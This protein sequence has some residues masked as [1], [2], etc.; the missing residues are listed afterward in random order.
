MTRVVNEGNIDKWLKEF[1]MA[2]KDDFTKAL[3]RELAAVPDHKVIGHSLL[4]YF[5]E[6]VSIKKEEI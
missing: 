2:M 5:V 3:V 4:K 6:E 1:P